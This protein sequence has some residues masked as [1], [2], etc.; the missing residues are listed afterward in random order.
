MSV[1]TIANLDE[2]NRTAVPSTCTASSW[3]PCTA[4]SDNGIHVSDASGTSRS[5]GCTDS[6][7][8]APTWI[9]VPSSTPPLLVF[10][11]CIFPRTLVI[12]PTRLAAAAAAASVCVGH[13]SLAE[14]LSRISRSTDLQSIQRCV[15]EFMVSTS[16][17]G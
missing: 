9:T 15:T 17:L 14:V 4:V 6:G 8:S 12:S 10:G 7:H 2:A 13:S 3:K 11:L 5:P 16:C 1:G